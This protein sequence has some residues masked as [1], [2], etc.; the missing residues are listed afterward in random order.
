MPLCQA[1][2]ASSAARRVP[3]PREAGD[4]GPQPPVGLVVVRVHPRPGVVA[5]GQVLQ[6]QGQPRGSVARG[7]SLA[8]SVESDG[9]G[10]GQQARGV[11]R[12]ASGL[13][14]GPVP[15]LADQAAAR[16]SAR[17]S[18]RTMAPASSP[19]TGAMV[20]ASAARDARTGVP[21]NFAAAGCAFASN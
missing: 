16:A 18:A 14:P 4:V 19:V 2:K 6:D 1:V 3:G 20:C 11:Q 12:A 17:R 7:E 5:D 10:D 15:R 21:A 9:L 8:F 13:A